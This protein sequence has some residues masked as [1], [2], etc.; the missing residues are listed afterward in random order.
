MPYTKVMEGDFLKVLSWYDNEW[1]Y[2]NRCVDLLRKLVARACEAG[3]AA[4]A[5]SIS[6]AS[7]S[8]FAS[9]STCRSRPASIGDDTR[10]RAS[11]PT[12]RYALEHGATVVL[13]S[14]LG[15]PKGKPNR[16]HEPPAGG[17]SPRRSARH[18]GAVRHRLRR[19]PRRATPSPKRTDRRRR[20]VLLE[21]L[22]FHA[23]EEKNDPGV[24]QAARRAR[25]S[26]TS[27]M[28]SARRTGRMRRSKAITHYVT[29]PA[30]GLLMEQ[31]LKYLGHAL[32][33]PERPFVVILGGAKVSDK[34]EVIQNML[35]ARRSAAHRRRDGLHVLQGARACR[36]A[37]RWSR[38]TRCRTRGRSKRP[39]KARSV[40]L[41]LPVDHVVT[42]RIEAGVGQRGAASRDRR[43][44]AI[45]FG[46]DIGPATVDAL[47]GRDCRREDRGLE[48]PDG[49]VRD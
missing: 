10:I 42:D 25:R 33:T 13:A 48:R 32:E 5:I 11:L 44:S 43:R 17:R 26:R 21:N 2:S 29:R 12:I 31:E 41:E 3:C 9:I 39:P 24:R 34:I 6:T 16:R 37:S 23:E 36:S 19:R 28:R 35:A 22:R 4:S 15:R 40:Q 45:G 7:A 30:A 1:G 38:T 20:I 49:R 46:V 27:T 47:R 14:H 8:S 18:A